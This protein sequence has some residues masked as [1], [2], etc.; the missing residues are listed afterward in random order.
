MAHLTAETIYKAQLLVGI[1]PM[2]HQLDNDADDTEYWVMISA[3]QEVVFSLGPF[4]A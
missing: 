1:S 2:A 4:R 3:T